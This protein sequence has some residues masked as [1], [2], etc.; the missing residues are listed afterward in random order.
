[1]STQIS[2]EKRDYHR[3]WKSCF[4]RI[5]A[6]VSSQFKEQDARISQVTS[7][8]AEVSSTEVDELRDRLRE[9]QLNWPI[10]STASAK[11][12]PP[13][14]DGTV[15]FHVF[16]LQF[17]NTASSNNWNSGDKVAALFVALKGSAAETLHT[18]PNCQASSYEMLMGALERWYGSELK[19]QIVQMELRNRRQKTNESLQEFATE[20]ERLTHLAYAH[21]SME[22]IE[23]TNIQTFVNRIRDNTTRFAALAC[24]KLTFA[25]TVSYALTQET[26]SLLCNQTFKAHKVE[27]EEQTWVN[28]LLEKIDNMQKALE[29]STEEHQKNDG[30][31]KCFN[32]GKSGHA[33]IT[34][35]IIQLDVNAKLRKSKCQ[36]KPIIK[37]KA[38]QRK[39]ARVG[40]RKPMLCNLHFKNKQEYV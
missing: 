34:S 23:D 37:T 24:P 35:P 1:M 7:Q 21:K 5:S 36:I 20:I 30:V 2:T 29:K 12:K 9:L 38:S 28:Q 32:C 19:K 18:I 33:T 40:S 6:Q 31:L 25:K 16:K 11:A 4:E 14:F 27:I 22:Y 17:K 15:P 3:F 8:I 39:R 13:S 10:V 26:A